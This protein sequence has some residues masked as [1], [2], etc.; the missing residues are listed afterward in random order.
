MQEDYFF[1][2]SDSSDEETETGIRGSSKKNGNNNS[3][4]DG[5]GDGGKVS[6]SGNNKRG[7]LFSDNDSYSTFRGMKQ[8]DNDGN[9]IFG[10]IT[11]SFFPIEF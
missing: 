8:E 3:D 2:S 1:E 10:N 4:G 7:G 11:I 6:G 9:R 5:D